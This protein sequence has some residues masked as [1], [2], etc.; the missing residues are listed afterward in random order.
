M[1]P[2][3]VKDSLRETELRLRVAAPLKP[4]LATLR[5]LLRLDEVE[6]SAAAPAP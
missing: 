5:F 1:A 2:L 6:A 3:W 4:E